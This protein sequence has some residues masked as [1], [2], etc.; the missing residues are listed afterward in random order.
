M[1]NL[2]VT[3]R[4]GGAQ[5]SLAVGTVERCLACE[6]GRVGTMQ[7]RAPRQATSGSAELAVNVASFCGVREGRVLPCRGKIFVALVV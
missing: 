4:R 1:R 3:P 7:G 2:Y 6:A 5:A